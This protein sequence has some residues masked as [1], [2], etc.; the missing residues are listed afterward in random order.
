MVLRML[1]PGAISDTVLLHTHSA[2]KNT[3]IVLDVWTAGQE[4]ELFCDRH[5]H[6]NA[7]KTA[8]KTYNLNV[9]ISYSL[10]HT[11]WQTAVYGSPHSCDRCD[12]HQVACQPETAYMRV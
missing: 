5:Y 2:L 3:H 7:T 6:V 12:S 8:T 9:M 10:R 1:T 11:A 4:L